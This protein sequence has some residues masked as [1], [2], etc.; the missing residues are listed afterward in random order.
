MERL[1]CARCEAPLG[2]DEMSCPR[3]QKLI[4]GPADT[5]VV[6]WDP[7][8]TVSVAVQAPSDQEAVVGSPSPGPQASTTHCPHCGIPA[9][10]DGYCLSCAFSWEPAGEHRP[11]R[12][13][14]MTSRES[15]P[16]MVRLT[17]EAGKIHLS[18]GQEIVLGRDPELSTAPLFRDFDNVSRR[19][20]TVGLSDDGRPWIRDNR[21]MNGTYV[22]P[23]RLP[24]EERRPLQDGDEIRLASNVA[25]EIRFVS[26]PDE[27]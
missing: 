7:D 27:Q 3:C 9:S 26:S 10:G 4:G 24:A 21:S 6:E 20:A 23:E 5:R 1:I 8:D 16:P 25:A 18:P 19:H 13:A 2:V 11:P 12:P 15:T 17:F 22:G 14:L